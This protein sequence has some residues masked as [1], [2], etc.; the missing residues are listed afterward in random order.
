MPDFEQLDIKATLAKLTI[1]QKIKLLTGLGWW[2]T[3]PVP[4]AG[5]PSI[6]MSD[7]PNGVRGGQFFNGVPSSCFPS[8][9]G[10][11]SSFDED[12]AWKVGEALGEEA[13][14]KSTHILLAPTVNI[15]RSPLGG[16][17]FESFS[18]DPNLNGNIAAAYINGLQSKGVS[19]TI[20]HYVANDQEFERFSISSDLSERALREIYL[21][22]FQIAIKKSN[23]WAIMSAYNRV[24][25]LHV[26]E[27]KRLLDDILRK[28]WG[29]QGTIISDWTGTYSTT[30]SI[31]AGLDIEMPGPTVMRGKAVERALQ[32]G[33]LTINGIDKRVEKAGEHRVCIKNVTNER[34]ISIQ[35]LN[36]VNKGIASGIPFDGPE[37][38]RDTPELRQLLRTAAADAIVLL[39]NDKKLLP[40]VNN[41]KSIAVIGPN[42]KY[43]MTSGGG[44]A[45]LRST[46]TISPLEG[47]SDV[48]KDIGA[49]VKWS[50]GTTTHKYIPLLDQYL[51]RDDGQQG[52]D[53]LFWNELPSEDFVSTTANLTAPLPPHIWS[54][55]THSSEC[56]LVD[57]IGADKVNLVCFYSYKAKF[58][59]DQSGDWE[60]GL[61][62][63]GR[64]NLFLDG[65]LVIDLSTAPEQG[66]S[67]FGMGTTDIRQVAKDLTAGQAYDLEIRVSSAEFVARGT[68]FPCWGG[69]RAGAIRDLSDDAHIQ[70]AV[71]LA[72][73]SDLAILVVG[74][75]YEW[76]TEGNDREDMK[77]PGLTDRLVEEVVAAN[78]NTIVVNQSGT[79]VEMPWVEKVSTL[80][81][82][83]YGGNELGNGLAD[84]IF[85]KVNPASKLPL[86]FPKRLE[87][88]PSF[89]SFGDKGQERGRILY[90]EGIF[91]GYRSY[92]IRNLETLFPFGYGLSYTSFDYS[93]LKVSPVSANGDFTVS[94]TVKNVGNVAGRE[95]SQIY[96]SD[97]EACL[98][99]A[100]KELK[101]FI[102]TSLQA[103]ES[104]TVEVSLDREALGFYDDVAQHWIAESGT[105]VVQVGASS[106]DLKLK[107]IVDLKDTLTWTGL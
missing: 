83:F 68:P 6:R 40:V 14:A 71:Q 38:S 102:K 87:D 84:V 20:K 47:I 43:A 106:V 15:Q 105:F 79:P 66:E 107:D 48:A 5:I 18:E 44:S 91:V 72:K 73:S 54:T 32:A 23:P 8:S 88:S 17:G 57:G 89:P 30:A 36:L 78:P 12:L 35:V 25:G 34:S 2:S 58:T 46:Y 16:R 60:F 94:F 97:K 85:G 28:E 29:Y 103:G 41:P 104:K 59:P 67:F 62:L 81:Q 9:T 4:E 92:D 86:T 74:L 70:E 13:R 63:A 101:G 90:N 22:P 93:D 56:F 24:N 7:G 3:E 65:K 77:L 42:A 69:I 98:P 51:V 11:G 37:E 80:L 21:K 49:E 100:P 76:E 82:A 55:T 75:N 26:S 10:L 53:V 45:R 99:R 61:N 64:G 96:I 27:N 95:V 50:L 33:K 52:A 39:K 31:Q 1:P 19:A